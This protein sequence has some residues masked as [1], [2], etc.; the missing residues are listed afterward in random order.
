[1]ARLLA[2]IDAATEALGKHGNPPPI[3]DGTFEA[4]YRAGRRAL[5]AIVEQYITQAL[6][7]K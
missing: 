7:G 2:A 3:S 4:G 1:M 6:E 5:R